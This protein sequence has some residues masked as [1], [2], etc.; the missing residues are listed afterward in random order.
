MILRKLKATN[1]C[2]KIPTRRP[3]MECA[4]MKNGGF[5]I[6]EPIGS[7]GALVRGEN[8]PQNEFLPALST[9]LFNET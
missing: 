4:A 5:Q 1:A 3:S 9:N 6:S 7:L 2:G 8:L